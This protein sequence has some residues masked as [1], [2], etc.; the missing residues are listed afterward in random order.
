MFVII[1][2]NS[3]KSR[4]VKYQGSDPHSLFHVILAALKKI[5]RYAGDFVFRGSL[6]KGSAVHD[7]HFCLFCPQ[8]S[9]S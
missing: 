4:F 5:V 9:L 2:L 6:N 3:F 8:H 1:S 7:F